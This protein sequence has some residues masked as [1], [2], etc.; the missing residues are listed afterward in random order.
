MLPPDFTVHNRYRIIYIVDE[1][2][3]SKVYRGR[4]EQ[5]GR[6]VLVAALP[7]AADAQADMELLARQLATIHYDVLLPLVDHFAEGAVYYLVCDDPGGQ[8]LERTLRARGGPLPEADTLAQAIRLLGGI[9][10]L[11]S[12][13]PPLYLGDPLPSDLWIGEDGTWRLAPF[14][15]A[16]TIGQVASPYRAPELATADA[17]PTDASDLYASG[18]LLYHALTGWPPATPE[19]QASTPLLGPRSINPA[20]SALAEQVLLRALQLRSVNRY[21]VAREMRVALETV[22]MMGGRSLGLGPDVLAAPPAPLPAPAQQYG[23]PPQPYPPTA[24]SAP[25]QAAPPAGFAPS[26]PLYP[27]GIYQPP[28]QRR[29]L[30]TGCLVAI[31]I[32]LTLLAVGICIALFLLVPGSPLRNVLTQQSSA[33]AAPLPTAA[34]SAPA[35]LP[36]QTD[37]AR[38]TAAAS[39]AGAFSLQN[40]AQITQTREIT[41]ATL[42]PVA[43][44]PDGKTLAVGVSNSIRLH[45]TSNLEDQRKI[46]LPSNQINALAWSPDSALLASG[47]LDD[48]IVHLWN[49]ATGALVR[50]LKGHSAGIRSLAFSPDG[51]TLASG[52][53]DRTIRLWDAATG[54]L[55]QT[56]TGHTDLIGGL[57]FSPDGTTLASAARDGSVRLWEVATGQQRAGFA[58]QTDLDP[59]TGMRYWTTGVAFSPDATILAVGAA[60]GVVHLLNPASGSELRQLRG[61]TDLIVIRGLLFSPDGKTIATASRDGTLRLW[62]PTTGLQVGQLGGPNKPGHR[63]QIIAISLSPD[64]QRIASSSDEEGQVLIWDLSSQQVTD[65]IRIGQGLI[66]ALAFS[67]DSSTLGTVGFNGGI[68]LHQLD[69]GQSVDFF[70]SA[71]ATQVL[72]FLPSGQMVAV[73]DQDTIALFSSS[74]SDSQLLSGMTG[75]P[76]NVVA[77][78][79]G[80]MIAAGSTTGAITVWDAATT[81]AKP[82]LKGDLS[83]ISR[84]AI[85]DDGTLLAAAG[86]SSDPRVEIWDVVAGKKVQTLTKATSAITA[87][88]F[89]PRGKLLAVTELQGSL[90]LFTPQDGQ[91][92]KTIAATAD[93]GWFN[94]LAFSPD[95]SMLATTSPNGDVQLLNAATG[96]AAAR[97][98]SAGGSAIALAFS[99]NGERLA[100]SIRDQT[101]RLFGL[102]GT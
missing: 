21:Q 47:A 76:L 17:E 53:V 62:N 61:H 82:A 32:I 19:Q 78:R 24:A 92:V 43:Y 75:K 80:T 37:A 93:Q 79:D 42:G 18:A 100:V 83:A 11:H 55:R 67:H 12:Q 45:S 3:G 35:Q 85:N 64:G 95:G 51:K 97:L 4:D 70:G 69:Q 1:R 77:S 49:P 7:L 30:S 102:P 6:L 59:S 60:D 81:Q 29:G 52:S 88:D 54:T 86:P 99:P 13:R 63:L 16:R 28:Q 31:A 44:A 33:T 20:L 91:L 73:S 36:T 90:W 68:R 41:G 27:A 94:G 72:A 15:L 38:P 26:G 8:D 9:D 48:P 56:L 40:V 2:P 34:P 87:L 65:S 5:T 14:T 50:D 10:H 22:Q 89:Q 101:V 96:A 84:L 39:T 58:F 46:T 66:T 23:A 74:Q 71:A 98:T 25:G 57:A